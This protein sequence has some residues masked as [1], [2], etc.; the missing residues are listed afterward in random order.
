MLCLNEATVPLSR[1]VLGSW[2][3]CFMVETE[4]VRPPSA[5]RLYLGHR[6]FK[7]QYLVDLLFT[8]EFS[9]SILSK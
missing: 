4:N 6:K 5:S 2:F 8:L 9:F 1:T 7:L 3:H